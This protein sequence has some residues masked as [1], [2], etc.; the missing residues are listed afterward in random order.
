MRS[1]LTANLSPPTPRHSPPL[2]RFTRKLFTRGPAVALRHW[3]LRALRS[4][5]QCG[6]SM[7]ARTDDERTD[8]AIVDTGEGCASSSSPRTNVATRKPVFAC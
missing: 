1:G 7:P 2:V 4:A 8:P 3:R 6:S 5:Y